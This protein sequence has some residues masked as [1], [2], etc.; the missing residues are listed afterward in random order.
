MFSNSAAQGVTLS[1]TRAAE[2]SVYRE[3]AATWS[4]CAAY[5]EKQQ[6]LG[7]NAQHTATQPQQAPRHVS[8]TQSLRSPRCCETMVSRAVASRASGSHA[9]HSS[10]S[11]SL[12]LAHAAVGHSLAAAQRDRRVPL[13]PPIC[14]ILDTIWQHVVRWHITNEKP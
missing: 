4:Q 13:R 1:N 14:G 7:V 5:T 12:D 11:S 10:I 3:T 9:G 8:R 2:R 6:Q